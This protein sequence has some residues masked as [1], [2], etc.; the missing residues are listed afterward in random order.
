IPKTLDAYLFE[1]IKSRDYIESYIKTIDDVQFFFAGIKSKKD[2][3]LNLY[4][5]RKG[6]VYKE[7]QEKVCRFLVE[8]TGGSLIK[9]YKDKRQIACFKYRKIQSYNNLDNIDLEKIKQNIKYDFY[10]YKVKEL[11]DVL[12]QN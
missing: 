1:N 2:F 4:S 7:L 3:N 9:D 6:I 12:E 8:N 11:I 10:V 5:L